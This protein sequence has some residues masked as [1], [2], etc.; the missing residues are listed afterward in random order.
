M[1][2]SQERELRRRFREQY[3]LALRSVAR[4]L[5]VTPAQERRRIEQGEWELIAPNVIRS[6]TAPRTPEQALMAA[7]LAGGPSAMA[8]HRSAACLWNLAPPP[9]RPSIITS[10]RSSARHDGVEIHRP[11]NYPTRVST[12]RGI[13]CTNPLRTLVDLASLAPADEL[14]DAIDRALATR[15][16]TVEAICAELDRLARRG[17]AGVGVLRLALQRRGYIGSPF[18]SVLESRALRLLRDAGVIPMGAEVH[19]GSTGEYRLDIQI[20][21]RLFLEVD[22]HAFH[23]NPEQTDEDERRRRRIRRDGAVVLVYSWR[24]IVLEGRRVIAELREELE[25]I[26]S[27]PDVPHRS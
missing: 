7:C 23:F 20:M 14:D 9:P 25:A 18:P 24:T 8:S 16:V 2:P 5:G 12:R 15:L 4:A 27:E 22:G 6:T 17:R 19:A 11:R 10:R 21:P 1:K 3:G 13:P 26:E